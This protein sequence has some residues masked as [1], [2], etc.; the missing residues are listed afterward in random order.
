MYN[1]LSF[2]ALSVAVKLLVGFLLT[3]LFAY[4]LGPSGLATLG[5]LKNVT[6]LLSSYGSMGMQ[7]GIIR[8]SSEFKLHKHKITELL[9]TLNIIFTISSLVGGFF[10]YFFSDELAQTIFQDRSLN[11]IFKICLSKPIIIVLLFFI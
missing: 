10:V 8:F 9:G 5:N 2:S 1:V 4:F 11:F 3:K 7:S 6:Q